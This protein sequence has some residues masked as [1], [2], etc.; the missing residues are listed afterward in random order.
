VST[1]Y[2]IRHG[3]A[4]WGSAHYDVLSER[5]IVQAEL[6]GRWLVGEGRRLD[7]VLS[8]PLER[9]RGTA[10]H[11]CR[12]ARAAGSTLAEPVAAP[13]FAEHS[14]AEIL[15]AALPH[16]VEHEPSLGAL[17][18]TEGAASDPFR[19]GRPFQMV[20][21]RAMLAWARGE[22]ATSGLE[23]F[24]TFTS[25]VERGLGE[26][27]AAQGRGRTVAL[28]TSAGPIALAV[29]RLLGIAEEAMFRL[30]LIIANASLTELRWREAERQLISFNA[31]PH[32]PR[33]LHTTR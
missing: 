2:L 20:F 30:S 22:L 16:L 15:R 23:P 18:Q 29:A 9:Q 6:L 8:G 14:T 7:A 13:E 3:Q 21:E 19:S 17:L 24:A 10:L 33:E 11:L 5:G 28:V 31:L 1:L 26:V 4:S 12:A 25:R 32:L 27:L